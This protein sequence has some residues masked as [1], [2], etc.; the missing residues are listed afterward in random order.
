MTIAIPDTPPMRPDLSGKTALITG[1]TR[2]IGRTMALKLAEA[3][4]HII[5]LARTVGGLE[6]VDDAIRAAGGSA[7][8]IPADLT[9]DAAIDQLGAALSGRFRSIDILGAN[10]AMLGELAPLPDIAPKV[11]SK[12]LET[13]VTANWRL[14]RTLDPLL[15]ASGDARVIFLTSR[16][17]GAEARAFWGLYAATKAAGEMIAKTYAL[18]AK[19]SG[20]K[21]AIIDPG[22]MRT[23]MRAQAMPGE[24]PET[25]PDPEELAPLFHYALSPDF[26]PQDGAARLVFRDWREKGIA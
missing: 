23:Q 16:V 18:E 9:D 24:K 15:R 26:A 17:G 19:I 1:A 4:A 6:E 22:A 20:V 14:I 7:S 2:G 8:L 12:T 5:A 13:N 10:A 21:V 11:W 25:L 3:G